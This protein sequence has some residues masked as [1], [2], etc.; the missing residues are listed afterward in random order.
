MQFF[1]AELDGRL[2]AVVRVT[3]GGAA[4]RLTRSRPE[5]ERVPDLDRLVRQL[6]ADQI[7][8]DPVDEDIA[9]SAVAELTS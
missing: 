3:D 5:W 1:R 4:Y 2:V 7:Y 9:Q 8:W 6:P